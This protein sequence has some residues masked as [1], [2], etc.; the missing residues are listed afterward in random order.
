MN[1]HPFRAHDYVEHMLDAAQAIQQFVSGMS[2]EEFVSD[3]RTRDAVVRNLEVL[4]EAAKNSLTCNRM[5]F[6]AFQLSIFAL[7][8]QLAIA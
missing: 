8:M 1:R 4:G 6:P 5:S 3:R 7:C 2:E